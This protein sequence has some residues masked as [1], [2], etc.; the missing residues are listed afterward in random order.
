MK[1]TDPAKVVRR[2]SRCLIGAVALLLVVGPTR[3]L[4][5]GPEEPDDARHQP[6]VYVGAV[7]T[8]LIYVPLKL[9][10]AACG[11]GVG[12]LAY[13]LTAGDDDAFFAVW[14]VSGGGTYVV[15]PSMLEGKEPVHF[16]GS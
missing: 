2:V 5:Q 11:G 9:L 8:N 13:L 16:A 1:E 12:G 6:I 3:V 14:D 4:A 10:Y 7:M 15:L